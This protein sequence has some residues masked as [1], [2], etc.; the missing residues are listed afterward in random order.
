MANISESSSFDDH[1]YQISITD[2]VLGGAGGIAN[3]QAQGLG[4]RTLWLKNQVDALSS[5]TS[6][7]NDRQHQANGYQK[8]PGGLIIQWAKGSEEPVDAS[9]DN[10][11]ITFPIAFPNNVFVCLVSMQISGVTILVDNWYQTIPPTLNHVV[12]QRQHSNIGSYSG[13]TTTPI[14][15]AV[16][17]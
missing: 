4:N 3:L 13:A 16:G 7:F 10:Q 6:I 8:F 9:E 2:P 5:L 1:I 17:N 14:I 12:V 15:I 11:I